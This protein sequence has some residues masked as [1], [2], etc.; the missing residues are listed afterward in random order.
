MRVIGVALF[1]IS[2]L[3]V[4]HYGKLRKIHTSQFDG[5]ETAE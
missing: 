1:S 5:K 3:I 4:H 2:D